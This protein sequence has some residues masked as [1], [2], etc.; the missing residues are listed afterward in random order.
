[1]QGFVGPCIIHTDGW[2]SP[3]EVIGLSSISLFSL[4]CTKLPHSYPTPTAFSIHRGSYSNSLQPNTNKR[5]LLDT[6]CFS[7][8]TKASG[9]L[10][11]AKSWWEFRG[12]GK[13]KKIRT[14]VAAVLSNPKTMSR[15]HSGDDRANPQLSAIITLS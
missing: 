7:S 8:R 3:N 10:V 4:L 9:S 15:W 11:G 12:R 1:M 2:S 6:V 14:S 5:I 13:R